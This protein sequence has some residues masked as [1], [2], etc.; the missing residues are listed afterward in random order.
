MIRARLACLQRG[1]L[2]SRV[3]LGTARPPHELGL[4]VYAVVILGIMCTTSSAHGQESGQDPFGGFPDYFQAIASI[5]TMMFVIL[6]WIQIRNQ[7][8]EHD[9]TLRPI[10]VKDKDEPKDA[11]MYWGEQNRITI[12]LMNVGSIPSGNARIMLL[13]PDTYPGFSSRERSLRKYLKNLGSAK[14]M[15]TDSCIMLRPMRERMKR[16]SETS[17]F[18]N[19]LIL[20]DDH[21]R[22]RPAIGRFDG[23]MGKLGGV[24]D[25]SEFAEAGRARA[26]SMAKLSPQDWEKFYLAGRKRGDLLDKIGPADW[27]VMERYIDKEKLLEMLGEH[28]GQVYGTA[29]ERARIIAEMDEADRRQ[30]EDARRT[31]I[32]A[33]NS[34]PG[35]MVREYIT[36]SMEIRNTYKRA[37]EV[38]STT[39]SVFAP[40][41]PIVFSMN[42]D[43]DTKKKIDGGEYVY[44]G[45]IVQYNR[46]GDKGMEY[47]Y[48][49]QAYVNKDGAQLDYATDSLD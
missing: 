27:E 21:D 17:S 42:V 30:F 33:W 31:R 22:L 13:P 45:V 48:Y 18:V 29:G 40:N 23:L 2:E 19:Y 41:H 15:N 46:P 11:L 43:D 16:T 10:I 38:K 47:G 37:R 9:L 39:I 25:H 34:L 36:T 1:A 28:A 5:A 35:D 3:Y 20:G 6:M 14:L 7:K 44:F 24:V 26:E 49:M 8:R 4:G 12:R 32:G